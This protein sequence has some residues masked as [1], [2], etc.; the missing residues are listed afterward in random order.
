MVARNG[1]QHDKGALLRAERLRAE[2]KLAEAERLVREQLR[3]QP[4]SASAWLLL[5]KTLTGRGQLEE[6]EGAYQALLAHEPQSFEARVNL[7]V[8]LG[9][10]GATQEALAQSRAALELK[11][12]HPLALRNYG[13]LLRGAAA[14]DEA[15]RVLTRALAL[16]PDDAAAHSNLGLAQSALGQH[17][18]ALG[19]LLRAVELEP[20]SLLYQDNLLLL[21]HYTSAGPQLIAAQHRR[22]GER[23]AARIA[24]LPPLP[25]AQPAQRLRVGLVS[26]DFRRHSVAF[27]LEPLLVH[28][29]RKLFELFA[30]SSVRRDDE[31]TSRLRAEVD[32]W[33]DVAQLDDPA[34]AR[35]IQQD[36]IDLL[37]DLSGHTA[38]NRLG[39]FAYR[40][41]AIQ[42][43]YLGYPNTT[44]L[45]T[46]DFRL[47]DGWADPEGTSEAL[48]SERLLRMD[49]G[50]LCYR[51][52][53]SSPPLSPPPSSLGAPPTFGSFNALAKLS[54]Q[55]LALWAGLLRATPEARLLIKQGFLSHPDSRRSFELRL[56]AHG[57]DLGRVE[58]QGHLAELH[59]HLAAYQRVDVALDP[60]PY[61]GTTTTCD[62]LHMGVPVV[63][64]AGAAHV[65]RVGV[66][67][68]SRV[69]LS[70]LVAD[71][72]EQYVQLA[73]AL[74][75][76][77]ARRSELRQKL[78]ALIASDL[79]NGAQVARSFERALQKAAELGPERG[80]E[81]PPAPTP[82]TLDGAARWLTLDSGLEIAVPRGVDQITSYALEEQRDWFEEEIHFVRRLL[83]D[84][85][86]V[87][88]VG[89]NHGIY[90]LDM[91]QAVG[92]RG[93][94]IAVEPAS[95][96]AARV[97]QSGRRNGFSQL[98]V[99][100]L[101]VSDSEG[102][103]Q[104]H[105][106]ASS[107]LSSLRAAG[108][109]AGSEQVRLTTL[110]TLLDEQRLT[111]VSFVKL[112]V[113]GEELRAL[114][115]ASRLIEQHQPLWMV[116][117]KHGEQENLGLLEALA[118]RG[119]AL[120]RYLPGPMLL[121]PH[122]LGGE[123]D[124]FLLNVFAARPARV[125]LLHERG[126]LALAGVDDA[127]LP[128]D[129]CW[130][131]AL[132]STRL[133]GRADLAR[134]FASDT[135]GKRR[136]QAALA[137]YAL[138]RRAGLGISERAHCLQSALELAR[139]AVEDPDDLSRPMTVARLA[140]ASGRR[141]LA[142]EALST[143]LG[144]VN[145]GKARIDEPFLPPCARYDAIDPGARLSDWAVSALLEQL[146]RLRS[147]SGFF[148]RN[149]REALARLQLL[150]RLGFQS[151]E[152]A[153]RLALVGAR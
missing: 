25:R 22:Y 6:A 121:V 150:A 115:G 117:R 35:Q 45:Q 100:A 142:L 89:A 86:C 114:A 41:A 71:T 47:T 144:A 113:E 9:Q 31:V 91:A 79:G 63:S 143:A 24:P 82:P 51:A 109:S 139:S 103:A 96:I 2:G 14:L 138:S 19:H 56:A 69:G 153:R 78:R 105:T 149:P 60:F 136:H 107:E 65:S 129:G 118:H 87:L 137:R 11:P 21:L 123:S 133:A 43:S 110:D 98:E 124:P 23:L 34:L 53:E 74:I 67:L 55:T 59:E 52:P 80:A 104:L 26:A 72:P 147:F 28:R 15:V 134:G 108:P 132:A 112:D 29:D 54:D 97:V 106:G 85:E 122:P 101:A 48:H 92:A 135:P 99:L 111:S 62:A 5:A 152:M 130:Q 93:R 42:L 40:P 90:A 36:G 61:H 94:V 17:E 125:A 20:D 95:T 3:K 68:L 7:G 151:P 119:H 16:V 76:D 13:G 66:S 83:R 12:N 84:G 10:R 44:G 146:E 75:R 18:Q 128:G 120:F 140:W 127:R 30:Y 39:V 1:A 88:D 32:L 27:F 116:E 131:E 70:D 46:M 37:V 38:G 126:L 57:I 73:S 33:R 8:L 102:T 4:K 81:Q 148:D 50:F 145:R 141:A 77:V 58:L 49:G 64:L